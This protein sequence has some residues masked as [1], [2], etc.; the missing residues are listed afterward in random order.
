MFIIAGDGETTRIVG[1]LAKLSAEV[2]RPKPTQTLILDKSM[3]R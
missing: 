3:I 2:T 1:T